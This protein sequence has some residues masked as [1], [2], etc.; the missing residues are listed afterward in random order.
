[1]SLSIV[2]KLII[3]AQNVFIAALFNKLLDSSYPCVPVILMEAALVLIAHGDM[4][5]ESMQLVQASSYLAFHWMGVIYHWRR[6]V[7][8]CGVEES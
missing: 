3:H 8:G 1:M 4:R 5:T 7:E 6:K 2:G